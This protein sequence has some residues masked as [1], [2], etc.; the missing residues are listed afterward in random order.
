MTD[1]AVKVIADGMPDL[2][3]LELGAAG[4]NITDAAVPDF[5]RLKKLTKLGVSGSKLTDGGVKALREK[6][7]DCTIT[8]K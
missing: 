1:A 2:E 7:P 3:Y 6:L 4:V 8:R 5:A